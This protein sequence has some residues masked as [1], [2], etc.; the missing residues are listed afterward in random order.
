MNGL[1]KILS[2]FL[3]LSIFL[4]S[5]SQAKYCPE[6]MLLLQKYQS[7]NY[8]NAIGYIDTVLSQC[9]DQ[10]DDSYFW[11]VCGFINLDIFKYVENKANGSETKLKAADCFIKSMNLDVEN[12]YSERNTK[13]LDYISTKYYNDA[14]TI[15]QKFAVNNREDA[16]SYYNNYKRLKRI[17]WI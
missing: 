7:K 13:A 11:H 16:V 2:L 9:P 17:K 4:T 8:V 6:K 15:L 14:V 10:N 3:M 12:Q 1:N 5:F